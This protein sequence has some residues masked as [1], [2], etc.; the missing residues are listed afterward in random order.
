MRSIY[1]VD[2]ERPFCASVSEILEI[3]GYDV[4]PFFNATEAYD[5]FVSDGFDPTNS[6]V[7]LDVT[8][9]AGKNKMLFDEQR[10]EN[11]TLTGRVLAELLFE[12]QIYIDGTARRVVLYTANYTEEV[13]GRIKIYSAKQNVKLWRKKATPKISELIELIEN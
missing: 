10:T 13:W 5:F 3:L 9:A 7:L 11:Y 1:I 6:V 4:T 2:D 8:L 12:E